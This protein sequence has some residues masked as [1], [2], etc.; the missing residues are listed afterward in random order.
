M[1]ILVCASEYY[2]YGSGIANVAYNVV[3]QLKNMGVDCTVCSPTG[4]DIKLGSS[5]LIEKTG[6]VGLLYYWYQVA[7]YFKDSEYDIAWLH[8]PLFIQK[9]PFKSIL[10]TMN[11]TAYGQVIH[12]IYPLHLHIYKKNASKIERY[13]LNKL[14]NARFT[15]VGNNI[16][17][18]IEE[19]GIDKQ[20]IVY[21]PNGVDTDRFKPSYNKKMVRKKFGFLE[22]DLII[23]SFG[24]L[25]HQKQPQKLID[26]FSVIEKE[27]KDVTLIIAGK[28]KLFESLKEYTVKKH[29]KN[30]K[31]LGF[32]PDHD[33]PDLCACS[34]YF[35]IASKYEGGEPVL[36]VAEAMAS[37]LPCIV[38]DIP[39]L[40][41]I[42]GVKSGIVVDFNN[43]EKAAEEVTAYLKRD[44]SEHS[45][46]AREYARRY[47][48][49]KIIA[50]KYLNE[51][52]KVVS[53][54]A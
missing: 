28:G 19:I 2:P 27:M 17:E 54:E 37:G 46:N 14:I 33:L 24:R 42:K 40:R 26:V 9:V 20:K 51:F 16:C 29:I 3:E 4:P 8:N 41:F 43:I 6:I 34:D 36:T 39:N 11:A 12:K 47:L 52:E 45:K 48:D 50:R 10:V 22:D 53:N 49:W 15:G 5:K 38:S 44:N 1:K 13:C 31:F 7:N 32:I 30:I 25:A 35:F 23:L 18:E 21:I